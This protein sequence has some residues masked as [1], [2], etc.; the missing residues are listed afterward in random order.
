LK[1]RTTSAY[2]KG[3]KTLIPSCGRHFYYRSPEVCLTAD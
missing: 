3:I 2:I 1:I